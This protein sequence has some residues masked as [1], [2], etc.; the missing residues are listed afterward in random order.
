MKTQSKTYQ[1][2]Y[3]NHSKDNEN[4]R[5]RLIENGNEILVSDIY[6]DGHTNT[7]KDWLEEIQ[8]Y[9]WHISC[10]GHCEIRSNCAYITTIKEESV[11]IRHIL[12]TISYRFLGTLTTVGVA[13]SLGATIQMSALLGV[14][15]LVMKPFLYFAH[16]RLWYKYVRIK[17]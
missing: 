6:I 4:E 15:E 10:V 14:G 9:K 17:K 8:D 5:W 16:E 12:K 1:I 2:R 13:Y 3:N 7:T 11:L